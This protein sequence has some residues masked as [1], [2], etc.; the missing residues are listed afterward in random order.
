MRLTV[1]DVSEDGRRGGGG[2][3]A[4]CSVGRPVLVL[5]GFGEC[6]RRCWSMASTGSGFRILLYEYRIY[7][8]RR[9]ST[10]RRHIRVKLRLRVIDAFACSP[11][12]SSC[13][14][15]DI[16]LRRLRLRGRKG[17]RCSVGYR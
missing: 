7:K 11:F 6:D 15:F 4:L 1:V 14:G 3:N 13:S 17:L 9:R 5:S 12:T 2:D 10:M 16:R 8:S